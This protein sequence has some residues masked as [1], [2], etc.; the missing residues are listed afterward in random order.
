MN[1]HRA[2]FQLH[3]QKRNQ[4]TPMPMPMPTFGL[5]SIL[6]PVEIEK[7]LDFLYSL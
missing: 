6:A 1:A 4:Q 3:Q 7:I 2:S 5:E